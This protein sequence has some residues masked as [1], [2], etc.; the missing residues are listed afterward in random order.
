[1]NLDEYDVIVYLDTDVRIVGDLAPA[2]NCGSSA[3]FALVWQGSA[4]ICLILCCIPSFGCIGNLSLLDRWLRFCQGAPAME[5][6][7]G[8]TIV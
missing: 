1:M 8:E 5:V 4:S 6:K 2:F 7:H 3:A